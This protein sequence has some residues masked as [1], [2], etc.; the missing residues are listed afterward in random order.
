MMS[1]EVVYTSRVQVERVKGPFRRAYLPAQEEAIS[2]GMHSEVAAHYG[3]DPNDEML[4][5]PT[6][7]DYVIAATGG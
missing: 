7:L 5:H 3:E 6:T 2:F 1:D 4:V